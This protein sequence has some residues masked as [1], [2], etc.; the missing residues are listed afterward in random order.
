MSGAFV[1]QVITPQVVASPVSGGRS[2]RSCCGSNQKPR[3]SETQ[4]AEFPQLQYSDHYKTKHMNNQ[5]LIYICL[6]HLKYCM[7]FLF[8]CL[9]KCFGTFFLLTEQYLQ[10]FQDFEYYDNIC[11]KSGH[12]PNLCLIVS[13]QFNYQD[14]IWVGKND[15]QKEGIS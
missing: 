9:P 2:W 5:F 12:L 6:F 13:L 7:R 11:D 8:P 1:S 10:S 4:V 14:M 15:C 3:F